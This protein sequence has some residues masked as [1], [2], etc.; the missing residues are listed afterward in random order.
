MSSVLPALSR[1]VIKI[2]TMQVGS[3]LNPE[4]HVFRL[5]RG[6]QRIQRTFG[7]PGDRVIQFGCFAKRRGRLH[8]DDSV[9]QQVLLPN[10]FASMDDRRFRTTRI[11]RD[12]GGPLDDLSA[13]MARDL[14]DLSVVGRHIDRIDSRTAPSARDGPRNEGISAEV[15]DV[16]SWNPF[17]ATPGRDDRNR[18]HHCQYLSFFAFARS[19][20]ENTFSPVPRHTS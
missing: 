12:V 14:G 17:R 9:G 10:H 18:P 19:A 11:A 16:F 20:S 8:H 5:C 6:E 15:D 3:I 7:E 2:Q 4:K 13:I 1:L